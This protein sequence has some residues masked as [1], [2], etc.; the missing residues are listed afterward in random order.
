MKRDLVCRSCHKPS[1]AMSRLC[2]V[3]DIIRLHV[4]LHYIIIIKGLVQGCKTVKETHKKEE[5][6]TS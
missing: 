4:V 3:K 1:N 5:N 2:I 6:I